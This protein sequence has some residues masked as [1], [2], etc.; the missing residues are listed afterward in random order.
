[1]ASLKPNRELYDP[2]REEWVAATPEEHVRQRVIQLLL[3]IGFSKSLIGVEKELCS[4][5]HLTNT[6]KRRIDLVCYAQG[7][8][9]PLLL[10]ECKEGRAS[11]E[12]TQQLKGYNHF[13]GAPYLAVV[14][15]KRVQFFAREQTFDFIPKYEELMCQLQK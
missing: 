3:K 11:N 1:M 8:L 9:E 2:I 14:D 12:A 6:P 5:P 4:L 7:S 15:E 10:I 13:V